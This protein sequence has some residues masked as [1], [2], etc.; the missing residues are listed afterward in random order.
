MAKKS[1]EAALQERGRA[2]QLAIQNGFMSVN[3]Q[4]AALLNCLRQTNYHGREMV[5]EFAKVSQRLNPWLR[6]ADLSVN[7][8]RF[9]S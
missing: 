3:D 8:R 7:T 2:F 6:N 5:I 1:T 9:Q 4:E